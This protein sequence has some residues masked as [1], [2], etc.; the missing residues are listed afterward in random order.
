MENEKGN[1]EE[2]VNIQRV[3]LWIRCVTIALWLRDRNPDMSIVDVLLVGKHRKSGM[4]L[5][6]L[7]IPGKPKWEKAKDD[8][9]RRDTNSWSP[10]NIVFFEKVTDQH[11]QIQMLC[12]G[13]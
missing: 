1:I 3:F 7:G 8:Q 12:Q 11:L 13:V 9:H 6:S 5:K 10:N 4:S 2:L